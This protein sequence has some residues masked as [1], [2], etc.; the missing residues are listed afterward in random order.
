MTELQ[1]LVSDKKEQESAMIQVCICNLFTSQINLSSSAIQFMI[2]LRSLEN[3][4]GLDAD[5][6]RT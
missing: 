2:I 1:R 5:G 3:Y 4:E 6:A